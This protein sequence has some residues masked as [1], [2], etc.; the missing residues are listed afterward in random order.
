MMME[1][2]QR[3]NVI[4]FRT[5]TDVYHSAYIYMNRTQSYGPT[6]LQALLGNMEK[7]GA[8]EEKT[9]IVLNSFNWALTHY[10]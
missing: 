9:H 3:K 2:E 7:H 6:N 1:A 5:R 4:E 10:D 8:K